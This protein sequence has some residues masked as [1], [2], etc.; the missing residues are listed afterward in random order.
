VPKSPPRRCPR[1]GCRCYAPCPEHKPGQRSARAEAYHGLYGAAWR[2]AR[3]A[4]LADHPLCVV[5]QERGYLTPATLIDHITPHCG[6]IDKFW[7]Q[8]NWQS[9]CARCHGIKTARE[10]G[11]FG[12]APKR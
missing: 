7:S 5:C 1:P 9:L 8:S 6:D 4:Y 2:R 12:N 10:D 11:G 3:L